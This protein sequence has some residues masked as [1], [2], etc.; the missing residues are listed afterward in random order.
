[1]PTS[2]TWEH[3]NNLVHIMQRVDDDTQPLRMKLSFVSLNY[4]EVLVMAEQ[5]RRTKTVW[6]WLIIKTLDTGETL[7]YDEHPDDGFSFWVS[8]YSSS[9][10][11]FYY[12]SRE[13]LSS[14]GTGIIELSEVIPNE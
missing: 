11:Y 7:F 12:P 6:Y 8:C 13:L 1:M 4:E 2:T 14:N 9:T 5:V 3:K 10:K